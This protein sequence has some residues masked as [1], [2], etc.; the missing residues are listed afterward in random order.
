MGEKENRKEKND[1]I[2]RNFVL[3]ATGEKM[4]EEDD[5]LGFVY[6]NRKK[7]IEKCH[8]LYNIYI[9]ERYSCHFDNL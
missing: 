1:G 6:F 3:P 8:L 5:L 7:T 9:N 2:H 4:G